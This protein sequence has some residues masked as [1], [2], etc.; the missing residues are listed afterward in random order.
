[1]RLML[2]TN[3][4]GTGGSHKWEE[5]TPS[6]EGILQEAGHTVDVTS[7]G[8]EL[9]RPDMAS[10]D[11]ILLNM[12]RNPRFGVDLEEAERDGLQSFV[13]KG[14]GLISIHVS[15]DSCPYWPAMQEMTA[16]GWVTG[17]STHPPLMTFTVRVTDPDNPCA[18]GV[19]DFETWDE[20]Y[21]Q[22]N[23]SDSGKCVPSRRVRGNGLAAGL[24][25]D[26]R[27]GPRIQHGA[28]SRFRQPQRRIQ[29]VTDE[30]PGV[31]DAFRVLI[32]R[33]EGTSRHLQ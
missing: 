31:G 24:D 29:A 15:P 6:L 18:A 3:P 27:Q 12:W 20:L 14:G 28:G 11:A 13:S 2:V 25:G 7:T 22:L 19:E 1:M 16:G 8:E 32:G 5:T 10:Y 26:L 9:A 17:K 33:N 21:I 30:R 23:V 4:P